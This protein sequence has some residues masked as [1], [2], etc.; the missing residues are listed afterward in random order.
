MKKITLA[1]IGLL[2]S[3]LFIGCKEKPIDEPAGELSEEYYSGGRNGTVFNRTSLA[4]EQPA[5]AVKDMPAFRRGEKMFENN[6][7]TGSGTPFTGLGPVFIRTSCIACHPGYGHS[8]R[9]TS[10]N[11]EE[12]GNGYLIMIHT[13]DGKLHPDYT[14]MVQTRAVSPYLPPIKESGI[15]I[16]WHDY[17]DKYGNKYPD[18]SG[19]SLIYPTVSIDDGAAM[20]S[21]AGYQVSIEGTIGIYGTGLLDAITD[22]DLIAERDRQ[23]ARG[24]CV[25]ELGAMITEADG[26]SHPGRYTYGLT[27]GTLQNGPGSNALW[28]ITNVTRP[29]RNTLYATKSWVNKMGELGLD[30]AGF[31]G[32]FATTE[33]KMTE[34]DDFMIWHRGLA[35]PAARDLDDP[36]VKEG[37]AIFYEIGC[38]AC[39]KPSWTTGTDK[40]ISGYSNQKIWPYTD[41]LKHDL[42]MMEPGLRQKCRTTPLWGRGL[43]LICSGH[44]D[45]LHD[46]RARNT[47]E[48]I[49]WHFGDAEQSREKFR[50]L[51]KEK[52]QALIR[53]IDAI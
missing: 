53:F 24:Y 5:P 9:V 13:P 1:I 31:L 26:S 7:V 35:V 48:A 15:H 8:K 16:T 19:Y 41:L 46:M 3:S 37:R 21:L 50:N 36:T 39:H 25:G 32:G 14:G 49:L 23:V 18:G 2:I 40:Y 42:G 4:F 29:D 11:S 28:N 6:Y 51:P 10:F 45:R 33:M 30:T 12:Y 34:F 22:A 17:T 20:F 43:S 38:T 47:E 52:R 44:T 27:R